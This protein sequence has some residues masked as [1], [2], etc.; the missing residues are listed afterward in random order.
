MSRSSPSPLFDEAVR[1]AGRADDD[2]TAVHHDGLVADPEGRLAR[3]DD[4][5]LRV[6]MAVDPRTDAGP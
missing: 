2:M 5:H 1:L 4:E 3:L 6:G